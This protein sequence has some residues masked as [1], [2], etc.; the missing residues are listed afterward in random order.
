MSYDDVT[1]KVIG[2][3]I[4]VHREM[5]PGLLESVYQSCMEIEM[6]SQGIEFLAQHRIP[7]KYKKQNVDCELI[8]DLFIPG[9]L[10][11]ELKAAESILPVHQAQLL[12]YMKLS[13]TRL[14][15]LLN[16]N[17]PV[18]KNGIKRMVL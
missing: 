16:F 13:Q 4:E 2:A 11:I 6:K 3:A 17:V 12:T 5:G 18:M 8:M 9:S 7:L 14:G 1:G 15:L 10:V